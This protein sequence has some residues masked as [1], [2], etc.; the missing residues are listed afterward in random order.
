M[1][2]Y[3]NWA[4]IQAH[5]QTLSFF[6]PHRFAGKWLA[7]NQTL[8]FPMKTTCCNFTTLS[9]AGIVAAAGTSLA[10]NCHPKEIEVLL[11]SN[12]KTWVH[13][14]VVSSHSSLCQD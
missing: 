1:R 11:V 13:C 14:V 4:L 2:L 5:I 6:L 9:G 3:E 12:Y 8:S 7:R 10:F